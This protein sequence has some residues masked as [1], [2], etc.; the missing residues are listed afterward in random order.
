[1]KR[2]LAVD[3]FALV[4]VAFGFMETRQAIPTNLNRAQVANHFTDD[5]HDF[6]SEEASAGEQGHWEAMGRSRNSAARVARPY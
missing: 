4:M 3:A 6:S 1:M 5:R 2:V